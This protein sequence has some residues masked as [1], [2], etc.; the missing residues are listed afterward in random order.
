M[1]RKNVFKNLRMLTLSF[2]A[3]LVLTLCFFPGKGY[4]AGVDES[5]PNNTFGKANTISMNKMVYGTTDDEMTW[6]SLDGIMTESDYFRFKAPLSG[7]VKFT[8]KDDST[9]DYVVFDILNSNNEMID[10][11]ISNTGSLA[12]STVSFPV[13]SGRYYYIN[14]WS[15]NS[16]VDYQFKLTYS[17]GK[18]SIS[19]VTPAKKAFKVKWVKK[20]K[21]SYYQVRYIRKCIFTDYGWSKARK[22]KVSKKYG[23]KTIRKLKSKNTYYVQVRVARTI[24]GQTY[25][26]SWSKSKSVKVK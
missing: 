19:S 13:S 25:Y 21:A 10:H 23:V 9:N 12:S 22:V 26:S 17:I 8:V 11:N 4:A 14:V 20:S 6:S 2:V 15:G 7:T 18:T 3:V 16:G 1:M 24:D 5:E